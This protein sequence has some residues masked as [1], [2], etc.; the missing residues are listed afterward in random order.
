MSAHFADPEL[1]TRRPNWTRTADLDGSTSDL[2]E[3]HT[4]D[5][6]GVRTEDVDSARDQKPI[7]D[8]VPSTPAT[9]DLELTSDRLNMRA[10]TAVRPEKA[11]RA[12]PPIA[13]RAPGGRAV[14][15][16]SILADRFL[17]E[18][19][20]GT[21]GT[22]L[23][24]SARDLQASDKAA[25]R[26]RMAIK[27]PRPDAKDAARAIAR[28]QHE[29]RHAQ[30][31]SHAN[32]VQV[33]DLGN[34][35]QTWFMT[36]ELIEGKSLTVLLRDWQGL[37]DVRKRTILRSCADALSFAHGREIV[38]GDFKPAN[39]LVSADG[40]VKVFDFGAA[41]AANGVDTRIPAGTPAYASPQVLSGMRPEPRDD[42]F[43]FACVAY[44]ILTGQHPFEKRSSL[45][46]R[47]QDKAPSRAWNLSAPQW[48][49][50]LSAL[51]WEREQRPADIETLA[52][53]LLAE[54][55]STNNDAKESTVAPPITAE[56]VEEIVP[57][58]RG[59]GF[60]SFLAVALA[61]IFV[62]A[63]RE[64]SDGATDADRVQ[65]AVAS[66]RAESD[67]PILTPAPSETITAQAGLMSLAAP[68]TTNT[69]KLFSGEGPDIAAQE[70]SVIPP[71]KPAVK[72]APSSTI[73]F[74][75]EQ[76]VTP[77]GSI[78]AVFVLSRT[79]P[80]N[81]RATVRWKVADGSASAGDD[82]IA[83]AEGS[84]DF[85]DGQG[86]RAIYIPLRNDLNAEGDETFSLELVSV[87]RGRVGSVSRVEATIRDDD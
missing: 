45:E 70:P 2:L 10:C 64:G 74:D 47:E 21:G 16:G 49:A 24:F 55:V 34:D 67:L 18:K 71:A 19:T 78:A 82:F 3:E 28:L 51:S 42:V 15:P 85:A 39:V 27:V 26:A 23:V 68:S 7:L 83:S 38:H 13:G 1:P 86:Q 79:P 61:V 31:L 57:A 81:G 76:I 17:L 50:L 72:P 14:M 80:L 87:Q 8:P 33:F 37:S 35:Q 52:Q 25:P 62:I 66:E 44:E 60:F 73:S 41:S 69:D 29:F 77:E 11:E 5:L 56:V 46:A 32:I 54:P 36:M 65:T 84:V 6:N 12:A 75:S 43:S 63:Q 4:S 40:S 58:Q 30:T 59:W 53:A 22:A 48:L 9:E 20:L